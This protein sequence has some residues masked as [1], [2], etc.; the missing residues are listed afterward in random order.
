MSRRVDA[1][2]QLLAQVLIG[3]SPQRAIEPS[4]VLHGRES[5]IKMF[6]FLAEFG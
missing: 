2:G 6:N 5:N 3:H 1:L 4:G